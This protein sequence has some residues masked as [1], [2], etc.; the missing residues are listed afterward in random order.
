MQSIHIRLMLIV[1]YRFGHTL[2]SS[3]S[4]RSSMFASNYGYEIGQQPCSSTGP[5]RSMMQSAAWQWTWLLKTINISWEKCKTWPFDSLYW[6]ITCLY[7]IVFKR[8]YHP[9]VKRMN[10]TYIDCWQDYEFMQ[11]LEMH[12]RSEL[13]PLCG[14]DHMSYRSTYYPIKVQCNSE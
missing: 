3:F 1:Y 5:Q 13:P 10:I 8:K 7:L 12:M 14:R 2:N 9:Q 6:I 4:L 11:H